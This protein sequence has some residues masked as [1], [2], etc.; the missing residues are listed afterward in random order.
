MNY[1]ILCYFIYFKCKVMKFECK[2]Q[3][4]TL[5]N[6]YRKLR[7]LLYTTHTSFLFLPFMRLGK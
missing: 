4:R 5:L 6:T 1:S 2:K 3:C 7:F